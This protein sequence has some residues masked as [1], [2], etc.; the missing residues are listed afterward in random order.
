ML[1]RKAFNKVFITTVVFFIVFT[2]CNIKVISFN[3]KIKEEDTEKETIYTLNQDNYVAKTE[4]YV[5]KFF[6]LEDKI[7]EKLEIMVKENNK[8]ALLPSYFKPILP[9]N[10]KILDVIVEDSLVKIYFSRELINISDEQAE[11]MI[12]AIIYTITDENILGIE[13]Y[14]DG[15]L[16]RYVPHTKKE[17]PVVLTKDF[18]INKK[19][20]INNTNDIVKVVM[21]YFME[22]DDLFC[23]VPVTKYTNDTREKLEI[24]FD[25]L[26]SPVLDKSLISLIDGVRLI[27]YRIDKKTI[28]VNLNQDIDEDEIHL[29]TSSITNNYDL[30]KIIILV[31]NNK[32]LVKTIEK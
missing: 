2:L 25:D 14:V 7:K 26:Y 5:G 3:E 6:T 1:K 10:T 4:V 29:I 18:G 9:E 17:L 19:Y 15:K 21:T 31:N 32:K 20:E 24:I 27:D 22:C 28:T 12:E 11:K 16:L 8:N 23:E 30:D 13:I